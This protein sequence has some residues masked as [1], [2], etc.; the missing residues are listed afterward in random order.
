MKKN[1]YRKDIQGMRAIAVL[2]VI[3]F[4]LGI[5]CV[6]GGLLGVD[7]FFV[8]SGFLITSIINRDIINGNFQFRIFYLRRM[9]R[10]L[11]ALLTVLFFTTL[12]AVIILLPQDLAHYSSSLLA[13]LT[14][15]AN[16]YFWRIVPT[17]YFQ[18]NTH[19]VPLIHIWSLGV[20]EQ[21]YI[22]WPLLLFYG[23]KFLQK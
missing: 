9:R 7:I 20:E 6:S 12:V 5:T 8:I 16:I 13:S 15:V 21:F 2:L 22:F 1:T 23:I 11:P 19:Y 17:G 10:I 4:H 14:S 18:D 3:F